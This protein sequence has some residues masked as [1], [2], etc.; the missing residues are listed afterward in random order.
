MLPRS[1]SEELKEKAQVTVGQVFSGL[2]TRQAPIV[3]RI[4]RIIRDAS[5][6]ADRMSVGDLVEFVSGEPTTTSR[7]IAIAATLG[8]NSGGM[9]ISTIHQAV[10]LIGFERVRTLAI[11][12]LLIQD[13]Q[14][15]GV[16]DINRELAGLS[17][18]SG[19]MASEMAQKFPLLDP[20]LAFVC[21]AL[22]N[23]GRML[24]ATFLPN[25]YAQ[26]IRNGQAGRDE[27]FKQQFGL[28]PLDLGRS[29]LMGLN[30][31]RNILNSLVV[32]SEQALRRGSNNPTIALIAVADFSLRLSELIQDPELTLADFDSRREMLNSRFDG[33]LHLSREAAKDLL[34]AVSIKLEAFTSGG[35][36]A[37]R[38]I[39]LF[40][41]LDCLALERELPQTPMC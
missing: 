19:L 21:G 11:S 38:S 25:E 34:N 35:G 17:L 13:A 10:S 26:T 37:I 4:V 33:L 9:E 29:I 31:P 2:Q 22:R 30:L 1:R 18:V 24:A 6:Q 32:A 12:I 40:R 3:G 14:S 27:D 41:R 36:F 8:Y 39:A 15:T 5:G 7:I 20:D 16:A 23:Y 28:S